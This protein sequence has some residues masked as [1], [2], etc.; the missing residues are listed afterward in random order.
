MRLYSSVGLAGLLKEEVLQGF[1]A[2]RI[3]GHIGSAQYD[4]AV[5]FSRALIDAAGHILED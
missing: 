3:P 5:T 1:S 4:W 2:K